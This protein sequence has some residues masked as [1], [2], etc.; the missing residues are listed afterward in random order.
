MSLVELSF[1]VREDPWGMRASTSVIGKLLLNE[2]HPLWNKDI[3]EAWC[4][5]HKQ[6]PA[7][8]K[9]STE[10]LLE[11]ICR[12]PVATLGKK[13]LELNGSELPFLFKILTINSPLSIQ[14]HPEAKKAIE[15]FN[16]FPERY[17]DGTEKAEIGIA[18]TETTLLLGFRPLSEIVAFLNGLT[19]AKNFFNKELQSPSIRSLYEKLLTATVNQ[20][21]SLNTQTFE[22]LSGSGSKSVEKEQFLKLY[23][24]YP[25]DSGVYQ[26]FF[27]NLVTL[28]P[29]EGVFISPNTIHAYLSGQLL[30]CMTTSDFVIRAGLTQKEKDVSSLLE[31][32]EYEPLKLRKDKPSTSLE[33]SAYP[34]ATD[35]FRIERLVGS[36]KR[37]YHLADSPVLYF[38]LSG[39]GSLTESNSSVQLMPGSVCLATAGARHFLD[40]NGEFYRMSV[41]FDS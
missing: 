17:Q 7:L 22:Q 24:M 40:L 3:G 19:A 16:K 26:I 21:S 2:V 15:L 27:L 30:E 28:S 14:V 32:I 18:I 41:K 9:G 4:G 35:K 13:L 39:S 8:L 20:I 37:E 10:N 25:D 6:R 36:L 38:C 12:D 33:F 29:A 31:T 23:S 1:V 5:T 34:I 11:Y